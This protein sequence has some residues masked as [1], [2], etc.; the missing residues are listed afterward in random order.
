MERIYLDHN[1]TTPLL[2]E[3]LEAMLPYLSAEYGNASSIHYFGQQ[4][5]AGVERAREQTARALNCRPSEVV[6]TSGGTEAD[7]LAIFGAVRASARPHKHVVTTTIEHHAVLNTCQALEKEGVEVTYVPVGRS[8]VVDAGAV[9]SAIR[10]ETVLVTVMLANNEVGTIQP[11][12]EIARAARERGALVHTDAVQAVGKIPV[13]A[14]ALGVDLLSLSGHK[15]Y[16]PKGVGALF[17]RKGVTLD[18]LAYG[19]HHERDRRAGTEN[20][21]GIVALGRALELAGASLEEEAQRLGALRDRLER[22]LLE[23]IGA[24]GVNGDP[25]RRVANTSNLH[26]DFIDG[27]AMV[28][29]LDLQGIAVSTGAACSSGAIEPSHVLMAMG[30][31]AETARATLRLSFGKQN[32]AADVDRLLEVLPA[33]VERLRELSPAYQ[34]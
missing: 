9:G 18:P 17:V 33:V 31:G 12:A 28:I 3:V 2:P 32:T 26:F 20:V 11:V 5:R 6:F 21:A 24:A 23:R 15:I 22:G 34:A 14:R 27:E 25:A 1:A 29:A 10:P 4:A 16:A 30:L 8:G 19:G 13:D 7:N